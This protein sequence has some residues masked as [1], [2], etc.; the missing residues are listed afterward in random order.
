MMEQKIAEDGMKKQY[1]YFFY[2][3]DGMLADTYPHLARAM[4]TTL[5]RMRGVEVDERECFDQLKIT[6]GGAYEYFKMTEEERAV[7][8]SLHEDEHFEP[9]PTLFPNVEEVLRRSLQKGC[10]NFIYTNRGD[11][12]H[13]YLRLLGIDECFTDYVLEATKPDPTKLADIIAAYGLPKEACVVVGDRSIDVDA[14][15]AAGV[16]GILFDVDDRVKEHHGTYVIRE[17]AEL[18]DFIPS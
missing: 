14:A 2:D 16:D 7:F 8:R 9:L 10:K 4:A 17:I 5:L 3:F 13:K 15:Y 18:F 6:L 11:T 12:V 1:R